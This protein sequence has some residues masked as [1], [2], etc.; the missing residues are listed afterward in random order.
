[1]PCPAALL[2]VEDDEFW[3]GLHPVRFGKLPVLQDPVTVVGFP[4]GG[5]TISV[6]SGVVSRIEVSSLDLN[7]SSACAVLCCAVLPWA[8]VRTEPR[9]SAWLPAA[10]ER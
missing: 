1:M 6:T 10:L 8:V 9:P 5:D 2:T 7:K 3:E 4:I